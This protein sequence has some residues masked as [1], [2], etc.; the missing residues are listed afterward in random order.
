VITISSVAGGTRSGEKALEA[1]QHTLFK[2]LKTC[3]SAEIW[4]KIILK[5]RIF[6]KKAV[7]SPSGDSPPKIPAGRLRLG[8]SS[9]DLRFVTLT[10]WYKFI[11]V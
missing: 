4:A 1:H 3:S 10:Y 7:K 9:S 8:N 11:E 5:M 6:W 2:H